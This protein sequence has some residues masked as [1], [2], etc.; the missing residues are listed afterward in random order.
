MFS[1]WSL[2]ISKLKGIIKKLTE[3]L[4]FLSTS[5]IPP[6]F[7]IPLYNDVNIH[8]IRVSQLLSLPSPTTSL[9]KSFTSIT[10]K[11]NKI[12]QSIY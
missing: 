12:S 2:S 3:I 11:Q 10:F 7:R 9:S 1:I 8:I 6:P 5:P 4:G